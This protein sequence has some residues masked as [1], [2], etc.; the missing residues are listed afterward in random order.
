MSSPSTLC[1]IVVT[2]TDHADATPHLFASPAAR[3]TEF[4]RIAQDVWDNDAEWGWIDDNT[5]RPDTYEAAVEFIRQREFTLGV[6]EID[7]L[8]VESGAHA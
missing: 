6:Y 2:Y 1:G 7:R 3:R 5:P 8:T 4:T